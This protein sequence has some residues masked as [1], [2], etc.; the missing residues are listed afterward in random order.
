MKSFFNKKNF[1]YSIIILLPILF[2][3][4]LEFLLQIFNYGV[5]LSIVAKVERSGK[6][7]YT[8]NQYVGKRYF[9]ENRFYYRK[10]IHDFFEVDKKPNTIRVFCFGASTTAGFPFEYNA[11][12]SEFLRTRLVSALPSKNIEVINTAIAA[13][14]SF[15]VAEFADKLT[16]YKPDLYIIYMGQNEFYGAFGVGSTISIGK[17]RALIKTFLWLQNFKAFQLIKDIIFSVTDYF[18]SDTPNT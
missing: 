3:I 12:P 15:T 17:S 6:E 8:L 13:T 16:E 1:F 5:D 18:S 4:L 2:I 11:I 10:G 14:N 7:Y 9:K